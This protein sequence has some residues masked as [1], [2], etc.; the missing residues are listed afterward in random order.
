MAPPISPSVKAEGTAGL[1][2]KGASPIG[3]LTLPALDTP[4]GPRVQ[5]LLTPHLLGRM[6][7]S[8]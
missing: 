7:R 1:Q 8:L 3:F 4:T 5:R 6:P 2:G